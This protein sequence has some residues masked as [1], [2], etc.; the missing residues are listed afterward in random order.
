VLIHEPY[1]LSADNYIERIKVHINAADFNGYFVKIATDWK[2]I[3]TD[4][5][6]KNKENFGAV[7]ANNN[8]LKAAVDSISKPLNTPLDKAKALYHY[9]QNRMHPYVGNI[10]NELKEIYDKKIASPITTNY[11]L[12]A[13]LIKAGLNAELILLSTKENEMLN[14][15]YPQ[16]NLINYSIC[17][18]KIDNKTYYLDAYKKSHPFGIINTECYN[19][20]ARIVS[21][22]GGEIYMSADSIVDKTTTIVKIEPDNDNHTFL[23]E[24]K[25]QLGIY[26]SIAFK[27]KWENNFEQWG[28]NDIEELAQDGNTLKIISREV[29]NFNKIDSNI[30]IVLKYKLSIDK[31]VS[32][33]YFNPFIQKIIESN[34]FVQSQR[35]LPI[36]F[37]YKQDHRFVLS[38]QL[39]DTYQLEEQPPSNIYKLD[40][41]ESIVY[42][43]MFNYSEKNNVLSV[44]S[45][46]QV[47]NTAFNAE[48]YPHIK[49]IFDKIIE[50]QNQQIVLKRK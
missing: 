17:K 8:F 2:S 47:N 23:V 18:L 40:D 16:P 20:Y 45:R 43:N 13:M 30:T 50:E 39:N 32:T 6:Y 9:V 22:T 38:M 33:I 44:S 3:N 10:S 7:Y 14:P 27:N 11:V 12:T 19:G 1:S 21:E 46:L 28:K 29:F 48:D 34:P 26:Q 37:N 25:Q 36:N 15:I 5:L 41:N 4:I 42:K 24:L 49:T 31:N 35:K